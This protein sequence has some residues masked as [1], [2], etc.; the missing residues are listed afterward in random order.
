MSV[1]EHLT[2]N[3]CT[4]FCELRM[5]IYFAFL[6]FAGMYSCTNVQSISKCDR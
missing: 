6:S 2:I 5:H 3:K 1:K 4:P